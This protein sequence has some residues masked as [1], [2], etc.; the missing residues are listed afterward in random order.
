[1]KHSIGHNAFPFTSPVTGITVSVLK[2]LPRAKTLNG[3]RAKLVIIHSFNAVFMYVIHFFHSGYSL[4]P[5][6]LQV[7]LFPSN[8]F[9]FPSGK[10]LSLIITFTIFSTYE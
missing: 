7:S 9:G 2:G 4:H 6:C 3:C 10:V 1:M 8:C 5:V